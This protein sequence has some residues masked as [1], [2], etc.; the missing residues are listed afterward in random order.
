MKTR[1]FTF[2]LL[3]TAF[4]AAQT[5]SRYLQKSVHDTD[6]AFVKR[7]SRDVVSPE[8]S[9]GLSGA[10]D[11]YSADRGKVEPSV[12][13]T[14]ENIKKLEKK[15]K[16]KPEDATVLNEIGQAWKRLNQSRKALDYF[17]QAKDNVLK[18][19]ADQPGKKEWVEA[20]ASIYVNMENYGEAIVYLEEL[21][22]LDP[23][24]QLAAS[25]LPLCYL[26]IGQRNKGLAFFDTVLTRDPGNTMAGMVKM[27]WS[28]SDLMPQLDS[29]AVARFRNKRPEE[30]L[31]I[32]AARKAMELYPDDY[33]YALVYQHYRSLCLLFK[34]MPGAN[35]LER[36]IFRLD[37]TDKVVIAE[38]EAFFRAGLARKEFKN[39]YIMHKCLGAV[40]AFQDKLA[41][42]KKEFETA[43][44]YKPVSK[45]T[46]M[47]NA[48]ETYDN[49]AFCSVFLK[50]TA[51][52]E[53]IMRNKIK[54]QPAI[55]PVATDYTTLARIRL[56]RGD[57]NE[58]RELCSKAIALQP[59]ADLPHLILAAASITSGDF[60]NAQQELDLAFSIN[61][62]NPDA[63]LLFG[64]LEFE[65]K[66]FDNAY[67]ALESVMRNRP[68]DETARTI[69]KRYYIKKQN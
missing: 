8:F 62:D 2:F 14:I 17:I 45:S 29:S 63:M 57:V 52:A 59:K 56:Y 26:A 68:G 50:D 38:L 49:L 48:A 64:I 66:N 33:S 19:M 34:L 28:I 61:R 22:H 5:P 47:D 12:P 31:D 27:I 1:F 69:Y 67:I 36:P 65:R 43:L 25:F 54:I 32:S 53:Q 23:K 60:S 13:T 11:D 39:K 9:L 37:S 44:T 16:G 42:A 40:L 18:L 10:F 35:A 21:L 41:E 15:L 30:I 46:F 58:A 4:A 55:D 20:A 51:G 3:V 24:N 7:L 6:L